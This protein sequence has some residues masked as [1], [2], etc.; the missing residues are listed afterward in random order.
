MSFSVSPNGLADET[1]G[2]LHSH[3][4]QFSEWPI[5]DAEQRLSGVNFQVTAQGGIGVYVP[6]RS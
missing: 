1:R 6:D 5:R 4:M 3:H 2:F